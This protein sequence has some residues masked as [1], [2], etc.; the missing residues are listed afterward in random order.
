MSYTFNL[1]LVSFI[2]GFVSFS[3]YFENTF[4]FSF[5]IF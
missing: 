2:N 1:V 3:F 4:L 5:Y